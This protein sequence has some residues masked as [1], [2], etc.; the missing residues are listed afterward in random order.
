MKIG[1]VITGGDN[2]YPPEIRAQRARM[3]MENGFINSVVISQLAEASSAIG[4]APIVR[5]LID[6]G[7][8]FRCEQ[9]DRASL[10]PLRKIADMFL[11]DPSPY[12]EPSNKAIRHASRYEAISLGS[13][14]P[15][16]AALA[17]VLYGLA[18]DYI[19][20]M[21][22]LTGGWHPFLASKPQD[23]TLESWGVISG[24]RG[25]HRPHMHP[26]AWASGVLYI[27]TPDC[28][29]EPDSRIGWLRVGHPAPH[30]AAVGGAWE[31]R[32]VK[33]MPG[34]V[35]MM[36]AYF[37]HETFPMDC[38]EERICVAFDIVRQR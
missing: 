23:F 1:S 7:R 13:G 24:P 15:E 22:S 6:Y 17:D 4:D 3:L 5:S 11:A 21:T 12:A 34:L 30:K 33:P 14:I 25:H 27:I 19:V 10:L 38:G 20:Q 26:Q 32:W 36:P 2:T 8:F 9:S 18:Q 28:A 37:W 29:S 16:I 35:V 31:E